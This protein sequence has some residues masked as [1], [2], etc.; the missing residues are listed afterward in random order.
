MENN[1]LI[2]RSKGKVLFLDWSKISLITSESNYVLIHCK[3]E[4]HRVRETLQDIGKRLGNPPFIRISRSAIVNI[5]YVKELH[6]RRSLSAE[7][8]LTN[9]KICYW[10]RSYRSALEALIGRQFAV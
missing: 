7:V 6:S 3:S 10:S 2:I 1:T 8:V 5:H 9:N 4:V